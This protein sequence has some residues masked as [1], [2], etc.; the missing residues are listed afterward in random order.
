MSVKYVIEQLTEASNEFNSLKRKYPTI[1][2][3][4][5]IALLDRAVLELQKAEKDK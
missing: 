4:D 3:V 1:K 5:V 2:T